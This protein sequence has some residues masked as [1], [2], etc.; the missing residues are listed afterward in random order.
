MQI[1]PLPNNESARLAALQRYQVLDTSPES[2]FDDLTHLA[3]KIC[4][5]PIA[6]I[7]LVDT[8]RQWFKSRVGMDA[9]ETPRDVAFCAHG[10]L[11]PDELLVIP[12]AIK[13]LRF[14]DNPLV[15]ED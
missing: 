3:A 5:T 7:S 1:A 9:S 13:D 6:L 2:D 15:T 4:G 11:Q 8:H 10:I 14:Y 12:N